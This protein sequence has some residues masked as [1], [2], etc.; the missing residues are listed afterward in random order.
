MVFGAD[1]QSVARLIAEDKLAE[2]AYTAPA[3]PIAPLDSYTI[4][5]SPTTDSGQPVY[6]PP[7]RVYPGKLGKLGGN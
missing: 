6:G 2:A 7:L 1:L 5:A 3:G 4:W